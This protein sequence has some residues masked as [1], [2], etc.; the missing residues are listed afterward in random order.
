MKVEPPIGIV[1]SYRLGPMPSAGVRPRP[2]IGRSAGNQ[3]RDV[4]LRTK[5]QVRENSV[6][7][8][9]V[10]D[11]LTQ[12]RAKMANKTRYDIISTLNIL[13]RYAYFV[14]WTLEDNMDVVTSWMTSGGM[15]SF[16][17]A[18]PLVSESIAKIVLC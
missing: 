3:P 7:M 8:I 14:N 13:I 9:F 1:T 4:I 17:G 2:V 12:H 11:D 15:A 10:N 16:P 6:S 18:L 5:R